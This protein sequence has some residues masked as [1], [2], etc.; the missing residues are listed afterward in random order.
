MDYSQ[1]KWR[2]EVW[3]ASNPSVMKTAEQKKVPLKHQ[4][5]G[6]YQSS[7]EEEGVETGKDN[8]QQ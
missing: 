5:V 4:D 7:C 2:A 3:A 6:A 1:S 8:Q